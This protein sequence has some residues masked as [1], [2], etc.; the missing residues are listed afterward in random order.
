MLSGVPRGD[1]PLVAGRF[2]RE[3]EAA[4]RE[5]QVLEEEILAI[6]TLLQ[7]GLYF[8][9]ICDAFQSCQTNELTLGIHNL[10]K[11]STF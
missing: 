9:D 1:C 10:M 8:H 3:W 5:R 2:V 7:L 6:Q 11:R 4:S